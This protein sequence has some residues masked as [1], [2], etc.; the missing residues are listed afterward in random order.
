MTYENMGAELNR[1]KKMSSL[2]KHL[3]GVTQT[4]GAL[5]SSRCEA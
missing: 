3:S 5:K 2:Q 4:A 1:K